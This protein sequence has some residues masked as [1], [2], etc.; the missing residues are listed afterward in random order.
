MSVLKIFKELYKECSKN[1]SLL[2]NKN[3]RSAVW[4][5]GQQNAPTLKIILYLQQKIENHLLRTLLRTT[6][7]QENINAPKSFIIK[8]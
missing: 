3:Y 1:L 2:Q 6:K 8:H 5:T 7:N 4:G